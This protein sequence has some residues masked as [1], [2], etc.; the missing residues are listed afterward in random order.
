M[1]SD[2]QLFATDGNGFGLFEPFLPPS[3]LPPVAMGCHR[4]APEWLHP[5]FA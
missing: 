3:Y 4:W 2:R 1:R 5:L